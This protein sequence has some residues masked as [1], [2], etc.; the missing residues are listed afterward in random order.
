M[1]KILHCVLTPILRMAPPLPLRTNFGFLVSKEYS[2][3]KFCF[4]PYNTIELSFTKV[5]YLWLYSS[6]AL[7]R[8]ASPETSVKVIISLK[9]VFLTT[10]CPVLELRTSNTIYDA[11][12]PTPAHPLAASHSLPRLG[13]QTQTSS[14][15]FDIIAPIPFE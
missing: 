11:W 8:L 10:R 7:Y 14:P 3:K 1:S 4:L 12:W 5:H 15:F 9:I 6:P 2:F 13:V